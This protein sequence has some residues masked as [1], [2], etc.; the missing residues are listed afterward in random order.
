MKKQVI[1]TLSA[2]LLAAVACFVYVPFVEAQQT[3]RQRPQARLSAEDTQAATPEETQAQLMFQFNQGTT[4]NMALVPRAFGEYAEGDI[5][6]PAQVYIWADPSEM[7]MITFASTEWDRFVKDFVHTNQARIAFRPITLTPKATAA[8]AIMQCV[9][10][11]AGIP[12]LQRAARIDPVWGTRPYDM[13]VD[14]LTRAAG[15]LQVGPQKVKACLNDGRSNFETARMFSRDVRRINAWNKEGIN[16]YV[17]GGWWPGLQFWPMARKQVEILN[18]N[19]TDVGENHPLLTIRPDDR[20]LGSP[21]A[22]VKL[23]DYG[24]VIRV[25]HRAFFR[26]G[27]DSRLRAY[28]STGEFA[29]IYRPFHFGDET[30]RAEIAG[31]CVPQ[32]RFFEFMDYLSQNKIFWERLEKPGEIIEMIA[33]N[34]G[35]A[36][37]CFQDAEVG[38]KLDA[39]RD[40]A[41]DQLSVIRVSTYFYRGIRH[42]GTLSFEELPTFI[43][44]VDMLRDENKR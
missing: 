12:L 17:N 9:G 42:F 28:A 19:I 2:G 35:A 32:A 31:A 30:R 7:D 34:F 15:Q 22:R 25:Q 8:A 37:S 16:I 41:I 20:V 26:E 23:F 11:S 4:F 10:P 33:V 40:E 43:K 21:D 18:K 5:K 24:N 13:A 27:L 1:S 44:G 39:A 29:Y 38:R 3:P 14:V 36:R 6:A